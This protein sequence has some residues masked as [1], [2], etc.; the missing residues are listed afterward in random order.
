MKKPC[1]K[2]RAS[3]GT[4]G[5]GGHGHHIEKAGPP[6]PLSV[7]H[8]RARHAP[9]PHSSHCADALVS[10][11]MIYCEPIKKFRNMPIVVGPYIMNIRI[12]RG[13]MEEK[14]QTIDLCCTFKRRELHPVI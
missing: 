2:S 3:I 1:I 11:Y 10:N 6:D 4:G 12:L 5:P 9:P 13:K 7:S 8:Y 14:L